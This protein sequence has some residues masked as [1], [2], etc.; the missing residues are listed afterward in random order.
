MSKFIFINQKC[1]MQLRR[2]S[3][4]VALEFNIHV[5]KG[6][7]PNFNLY[8]VWKCFDL[9]RR[10]GPIGRRTL[11]SMMKLSEASTRTLLEHLTKEGCLE[12]TKRG[13][14]IT[15]RGQEK[16]QKLGM[17]I[18]E[19]GWVELS[20]GKFNCCVLVR[21]AADRVKD[22]IRERDEA[23]KVGAKGAIILVAKNGKVIFPTDE[24][25][26]DQKHIEPLRKFFTIEDGDVLIIAGADEYSSAEMGA[27]RAGLS[28]TDTSN[29]CLE[30]IEKIISEENE[31]EDIK[32]IALMVHE[33]VGRLPVTM[34]SRNHYGVRCEDGKIIETNFTGPV[35]EETL[36][37]GTVLRRISK[38]GKYR[39]CPVLAVPLIRK[40]EVIAVVG[41]FDITRG[42]YAEW[43]SRIKE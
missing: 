11:A 20:I 1:D 15:Q 41:V 3:I 28:L 9:V 22:G 4:I 19:L 21:K 32:S 24:R 36:K 7:H 42:S 18:I 17:E 25:F 34:R 6:P 38:A 39:G 43:M 35:L 30:K 16:F 23:V 29:G 5:H 10:N 13:A 26:P 14:V 27:I 2:I 8:H 40:N 33:I 31:E 37:K 12:L